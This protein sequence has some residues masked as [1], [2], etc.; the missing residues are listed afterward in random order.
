MK[1]EE[2]LKRL[3]RNDFD[4]VGDEPMCTDK[5]FQAIDAAKELGFNDLAD[6]MLNDLENSERIDYEKRA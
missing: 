3:I 1:S 4:S 2:Y 6:E 5:L